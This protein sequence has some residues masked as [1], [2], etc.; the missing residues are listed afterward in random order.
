[1]IADFEIKQLD[2]G[3]KLTTDE[4]IEEEIKLLCQISAEVANLL[5]SCIRLSDGMEE[6]TDKTIYCNEISDLRG[7][8][9]GEIACKLN[10][11]SYDSSKTYEEN[12]DAITEDITQSILD[13]VKD[14]AGYV[15]SR[16][17]MPH[18]ENIK[19]LVKQCVMKWILP[20]EEMSELIKKGL[21]NK[22][23]YEGDK[24]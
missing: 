12:V 23:E 13:I 1:M 7:D 17:E 6:L 18:S 24:Y 8:L 20:G 21:F 5:V 14:N 22:N 16:S 15:V 2:G 11:P 9:K 19:K 10:K 4:H 3:R